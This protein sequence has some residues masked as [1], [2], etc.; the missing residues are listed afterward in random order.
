MR[1]G[2]TTPL[3][4]PFRLTGEL[5]KGWQ[6]TRVSFGVVGGR[7]IGAGIS[8]GPA[9]DPTALGV[10]GSTMPVPF[11]CNFV[12]GQSSYV[13][14]LGVQ[15]VY[16]VLAEPDK[17]WQSLCASRPINGVAGVVVSMDMNTPG[18]NAPLPGSA[19]LGGV[20]GVLTRLRFLGPNASAWT[21]IPIG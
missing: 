8:A 14:R 21:T 5:P 13:T 19:Q 6:L 10:G 18:S 11:G 7:L 4:F 15:W 17:Q 12:D 1:Y 16:R 2:Q 3:K 9:V 20:L